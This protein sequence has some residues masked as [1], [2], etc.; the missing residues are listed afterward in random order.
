MGLHLPERPLVGGVG[1]LTLAQRGPG[2]RLGLFQAARVRH[3]R[4][5]RAPIR[6]AQLGQLA[7]QLGQRLGVLGR[8]VAAH[9][10]R[11]AVT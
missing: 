10:Q 3:Q 5:A 9:L 8:V 4:L 7:R 11:G 2:L 1:G 6:L